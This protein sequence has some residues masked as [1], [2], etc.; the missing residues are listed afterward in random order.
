MDDARLHFSGSPVLERRPS[1]SIDNMV[2]QPSVHDHQGNKTSESEYDDRNIGVESEAESDG[3]N[4]LL[5]GIL[6]DI[7]PVKLNPVMFPSKPRSKMTMEVVIPTPHKRPITPSKAV[8]SEEGSPSDCPTD[9]LSKSVAV[10]RGRRITKRSDKAEEAIRSASKGSRGTVRAVE[11]VA[12]KA[13][14]SKP[15]QLAEGAANAQDSDQLNVPQFN[16]AQ[17]VLPDEPHHPPAYDADIESLRVELEAEIED[18]ADMYLRSSRAGEGQNEMLREWS[19]QWSQ[20]FLAK[21]Y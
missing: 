21:L 19:E 18:I 6:T 10:R 8:D 1:W 12:S 9:D 20:L 16:D 4:R 11:T 15:I 17:H 13:S 2:G 5:Q 7:S 14:A 3:E